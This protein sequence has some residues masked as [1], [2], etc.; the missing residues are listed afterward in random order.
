MEAGAKKEMIA[1]QGQMYKTP[2]T[3]EAELIQNKRTNSATA[4]L[5]AHKRQLGIAFAFNLCEPRDR[6][7][8][9]FH[10]ESPLG[11]S[12]PNIHGKPIRFRPSCDIMSKISCETC[13][14]S[15]SYFPAINKRASARTVIPMQGLTVE[16]QAT[17]SDDGGVAI[18]EIIDRL[19]CRTIAAGRYRK[20][21]CNT[22]LTRSL[23]LLKLRI[24]P[25][26]LG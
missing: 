4:P 17:V 20:S 12:T 15:V 23:W 16:Q 24:A 8:V 5:D 10:E 1:A 18:I 3:N 6:P 21:G 13:Y 11:G 22:I 25:C 9:L 7:E 19:E 14:T 2:A 26:G